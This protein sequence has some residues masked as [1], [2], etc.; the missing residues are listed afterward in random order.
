ML[1]ALAVVGDRFLVWHIARKNIQLH[2]MPV[3]FF[4]Y[5]LNKFAN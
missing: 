4:S 1:M 5:F 3:K 2:Q